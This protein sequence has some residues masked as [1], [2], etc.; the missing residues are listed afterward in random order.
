MSTPSRMLPEGDFLSEVRIG[1]EVS[2]SRLYSANM[3]RDTRVIPIL[4][5]ATRAL[6]VLHGPQSDV[7]VSRIPAIFRVLFPQQPMSYQDSLS[8]DEASSLACCVCYP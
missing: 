2:A 6:L 7:P 5:G 3:D 4:C 1:D 8:L